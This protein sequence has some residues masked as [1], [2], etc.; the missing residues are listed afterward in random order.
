MLHTDAPGAI[1]AG[2]VD[3][4]SHWRLRKRRCISNVR[5]S[6]SA[7]DGIQSMESGF[8]LVASRAKRHPAEH[9]S[10]CVARRHGPSTDD[11][12]G[13]RSPGPPAISKPVHR[14]GSFDPD[15]NLAWGVWNKTPHF[16]VIVL[17]GLLDQLSCL[18]IRHRKRLLSRMQINAYNSRV[19][20]NSRKGYLDCGYWK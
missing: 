19:V 11:P 16:V 6:R 12:P 13:S 3:L 17:Q 20:G 4:C 15:Q 5:R 9:A 2:I 1:L 14:P 8:L 7:V 10:A 18:G